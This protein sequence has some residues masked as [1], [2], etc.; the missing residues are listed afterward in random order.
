MFDSLFNSE[1]C[2]NFNS[3]YFEEHL[4][5]AASKNAF[6]KLRKIKNC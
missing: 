3:I 2:D 1:H 4:R 6:M 5:T